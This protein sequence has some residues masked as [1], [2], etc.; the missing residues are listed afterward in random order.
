MAPIQR[1][2]IIDLF[3]FACLHLKKANSSDTESPFSDL[4]LSITYGIVSSKIYDKE[5][6][7]NFDIVNLASILLMEMSVC[8]SQ[9]YVA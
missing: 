8:L 6:D 1:S 2:I 3:L 4:D 9:T 5:A 7:L